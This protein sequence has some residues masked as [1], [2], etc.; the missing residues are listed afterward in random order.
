MHPV[1]DGA[2]HLLLGPVGRGRLGELPRSAATLPPAP[3]L[4]AVTIWL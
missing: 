4:S 3:T 2:G 1:A